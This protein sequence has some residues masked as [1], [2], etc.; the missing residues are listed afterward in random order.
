MCQD[1]SALISPARELF[2][3]EW[4]VPRN[5]EDHFLSGH[6][7]HLVPCIS[8]SRLTGA[9]SWELPWTQ[10]WDSNN[11]S[12]LWLASRLLFYLWSWFLIFFW[13]WFY[14][15]SV[16]NDAEKSLLT[17]TDSIL[18]Q[19]FKSLMCTFKYKWGIFICSF[20]GTVGGREMGKGGACRPTLRKQES[21]GFPL[22]L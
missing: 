5:D 9:W 8:K 13:L 2:G 7:P 19:A 18:K 6:L 14:Q 3:E 15:F 4:N 16:L 17:P 11:Q 20:L 12:F 22:D 10:G 1:P 21:W